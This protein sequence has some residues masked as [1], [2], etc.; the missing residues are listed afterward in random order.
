[1][2]EVRARRLLIAA[3]QF[4]CFTGTHV[5]ILTPTDELSALLSLLALLV[6]T[7]KF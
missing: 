2:L 4:A 7:H 3:P 5:Q 6:Q 1:M